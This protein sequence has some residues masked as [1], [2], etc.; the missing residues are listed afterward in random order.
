MAAIATFALKAG[1]WFR[2]GL[3]LIISPVRGDYRRCQAEIPL[4]V[5]CSFPG[6]ALERD[7]IGNGKV[8]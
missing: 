1:E 6:P 2:R 3:L 8:A 5:L 4:I 7:V